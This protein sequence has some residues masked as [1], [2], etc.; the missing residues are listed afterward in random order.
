MS[1]TLYVSP[2]GNDA[3][4]GRI[5]A[6]NASATDGPFATIDRARL[7]VRALRE[8]GPAHPVSVQIRNGVYFLTSPLV[9]TPEDSGAPESP[10]VYEAYPGESPVIS[11]GV[12]H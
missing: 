2:E 3:W 12:N 6:P 8:R 10:V 1:L 4:S 7:A 9:F 5:E 11:G